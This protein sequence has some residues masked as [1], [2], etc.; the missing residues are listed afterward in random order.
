MRRDAPAR[1]APDVCRGVPSMPAS[2]F[3]P[4]QGR[5][6]G[7]GREGEKRTGARRAGHFAPTLPRWQEDRWSGAKGE[8]SRGDA[9]LHCEHAR[10]PTP[11]EAYASPRAPATAPRGAAFTV[12]TVR[13]TTL[14]AG[15]AAVNRAMRPYLFHTVSA[16]DIAV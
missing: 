5:Q 12:L 16:G 4:A 9:W 6:R 8:E 15:E 1:H 14:T 11:D 7:T 10:S 13:G 3:P 2:P